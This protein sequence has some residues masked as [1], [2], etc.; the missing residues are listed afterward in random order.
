[1]KFLF[2]IIFLISV[3]HN[4]PVIASK[5]GS[6]DIDN[7]NCPERHFCWPKCS[8]IDSVFDMEKMTCRKSND[9]EELIP[10]KVFG[11]T[12]NQTSF[13]TLTPFPNQNLTA[14]GNYGYKMSDGECNGKLNLKFPRKNIEVNL[15]SD[16]RLYID[17]RKSVEIFQSGFCVENFV[18]RSKDFASFS[19]F[20]CLPFSPVMRF[21]NSNI[22]NKNNS[23]NSNNKSNK[24]K[25]NSNNNNNNSNNKN[26]NNKNTNSNN[27]NINNNNSSHNNNNKNISN[28]NS[29]SNNNNSNSNNINNN[30]NNNITNNNNNINN[31]KNSS[32]CLSNLNPKVM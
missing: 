1:M 23:N 21:Q 16:G 18:D 32:S 3:M 29:K 5:N 19:A 4:C 15:L 25:N 14:D 6:Q 31:N 28:K 13:P 30:N 17:N 11:M 24:N 12:I 22:Q 20:I 9:S 27:R 10:P 2:G 7:F 8:Q 26:I